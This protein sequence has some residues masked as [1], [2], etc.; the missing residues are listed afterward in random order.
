MKH[1]WCPSFLHTV[2]KGDSFLEWSVFCLFYTGLLACFL[3]HDVQGTHELILILDLTVWAW[4][5]NVYAA[6]HYN[7]FLALPWLR[8]T[9]NMLYSVVDW[10]MLCQRSCL[11]FEFHCVVPGIELWGLAH[12]PSSLS[13]PL[14][15]FCC[16]HFKFQMWEI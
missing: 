11:G 1:S 7:A 9:R 2:H 3:P 16:C 4:C 8:S 14:G 6:W 10:G 13:F 5:F 15:L 12:T